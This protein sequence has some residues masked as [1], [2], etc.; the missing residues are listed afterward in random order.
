MLGVSR[1]WNCSFSPALSIYPCLSF[2]FLRYLRLWAKN[3]FLKQ[4]FMENSKLSLNSSGSD[5]SFW[6]SSSSWSSLNISDKKIRIITGWKICTTIKE[7]EFYR[8]EFKRNVSHSSNNPSGPPYT[9]NISNQKL[10]LRW[11]VF[12]SFNNH[13]LITIYF[14]I[15]S[16]QFSP[17]L[18]WAEIPYL[19]C[20]SCLS[21]EKLSSRCWGSWQHMQCKWR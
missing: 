21:A 11:I 16:L 14:Y 12:K 18:R 13:N 2:I 17:G 8:W 9:K 1:D 7:F 5:V 4:Q 15:I 3:A 19:G 10:I 6:N 20:W